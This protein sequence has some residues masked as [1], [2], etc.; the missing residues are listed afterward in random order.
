MD[1]VPRSERELDDDNSSMVEC[2][3]EQ[4]ALRTLKPLIEAEGTIGYEAKRNL[5]L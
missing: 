5:G 3:T 1:P 2:L 4:V